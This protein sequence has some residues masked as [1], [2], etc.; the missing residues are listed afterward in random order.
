M[1]RDRSIGYGLALAA[2]FQLLA[3]VGTVLPPGPLLIGDAIVPVSL[4]I[5]FAVLG[6]GFLSDE[7]NTVDGRW[8][9]RVMAVLIAFVILV[10]GLNAFFVLT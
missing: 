8:G 2:G 10:G 4:C 6:A 7:G 3:L 5:V 9:W 1:D